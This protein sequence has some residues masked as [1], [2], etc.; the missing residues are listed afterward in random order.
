MLGN[1]LT[2][3]QQTKIALVGKN[4]ILILSII[5]SRWLLSLV[6]D[7]TLSDNSNKTCSIETDKLSIAVLQPLV[8]TL[9]GLFTL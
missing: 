9:T 8:I 4:I 2:T 3:S 1:M 6:L 7:E 5:S